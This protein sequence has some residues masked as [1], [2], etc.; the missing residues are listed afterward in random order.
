[1]STIISHQPFSTPKNINLKQGLLRFGVKQT[2]NKYGTTDYGLYVN[3]SGGLVFSSAGSVSVLSASGPASIPTWDNI[4]QADQSMDL[5]ALSTFTI[6]RSSGNNDVLTLTNTGTGSGVLLQITNVGTGSDISGTGATWSFSKAG[7]NVMKSTTIAGTAGTTSIALTLGDIVVSAGGLSLTKA[8]NNATLS[9]TNNTATSA[10]VFVF[11]GSGVFTGSTTTSFMTLTASGLTTGTVLYIPV[12]ALTTGKALNII[13]TTAQ[14]TGIYVNIES[15][16]T[17]TSLTGAGRLLRVAHTGTGTNSGILSE[18]AS[19]AADET[20][21]LKVTASGVLATGYGIQVSG[22]LVTTGFGITAADFNS[23]TSGIAV[24]IASSSTNLTGAGRLLS[25]VHSGASTAATTAKIVEF[26][27]AATENTELFKLTATGA[28][29]A[30]LMM[31]ISAAAMTT[32]TGIAM[33]DL[34]ALTTGVGISIAHGTSAIGDTGSL[35]RLASTGINTGGAT[36]GTMIDCQTTAQVAGT[37]VYIA[38]GAMTTGVLVSLLSTTGMTSGSLLRATTST[39]GA[40]ATNG[41]ISFR[42]TGAYTSTSNAGLLDVSASATTAGTVV[43]IT[44]TSAGQTATQLLNVTASG[45]TTG[46]TGNV[47]QITGCGTTGASN[48]LA[49]I[50]VNTTAGSIV[51]ITNASASQTGA[52]LLTVTQSGTTT[53]FTGNVASITSSS[54]TGA[55]SGLKITM[56]N[57]TAGNGLSIVS[58]ALTLGAATGILVSH[59][60]SILG[61]GTSLV[62]ISSTGVDTGTTTGTL[63]DLSQTAAAGNVAALITD[64]SA[65]ASARTDLKINVTN[66]AAVATIPLEI[67]NAAVTGA[68]SKFKR[69]GKFGT[70]T[71]YVGIDAG[72]N[73]G[74]GQLT[75]VAGDILFNG[76]SN[77]IEYCDADGTNWTSTV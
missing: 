48:T 63:L 32:G 72:G 59:T 61:A 49:V 10:S 60:T 9:V 18:F 58:N 11:A 45:Y 33:T 50:G 4:F 5:A 1:M 40:V 41:I 12:A 7:V 76:G 73:T 44:A 23:L 54:T 74:E 55:G 65:N 39:A 38:G 28:M 57:T 66:A 37:Q 34:A 6:D 46:Y 70:V 20:V 31:N 26:S 15:G 43:H 2:S 14:T 71:L 42:A 47:V 19:A 53:G 51:S 64:A 52:E 8:A 36:N 77:K 67:Q 3:S 22:A 68:N 62:R 56:V 25:V 27:S 17:G 29:A 21:I 69:I 24:S 16:T 35:L 30:G 75:G 13:G